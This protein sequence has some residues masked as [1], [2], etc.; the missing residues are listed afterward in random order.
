MT[1]FDQLMLLVKFLFGPSEL[2][3]EALVM[4]R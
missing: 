2:R 3:C 1:S 4:M